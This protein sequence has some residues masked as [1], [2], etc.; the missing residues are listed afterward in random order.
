M[1]SLPTCLPP[2]LPTSLSL[3]R[4]L[5]L[6][7]SLCVCVCMRVC[8][9]VCVCVGVPAA[10]CTAW[11]TMG[12]T[13]SD[14]GELDA[15]AR[16]YQ[17]ALVLKPTMAVAHTSLVC[18]RLRAMHHIDMA[19]VMAS[20]MIPLLYSNSFEGIP[21]TVTMTMSMTTYDYWGGMPTG[22]GVSNGY[23]Y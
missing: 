11:W 5:S 16:A 22:F 10:S 8:V 20:V 7:L 14:V 9:Y 19:R 6:S 15:A 1:H 3:A 13:Y 21:M 17:Q 2:F 18:L 12:N 4:S 23:F